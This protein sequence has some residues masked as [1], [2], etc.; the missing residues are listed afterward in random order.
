MGYPEVSLCKLKKLKKYPV[1]SSRNQYCLMV[2]CYFSKWLECFPVPDQ[3]VTTVARKLVYE[4]VARYGAFR[5]LHSDQGTSFGSKVVGEVCQLFGI[6][7]TRTMPYHP[8]S[9]GFIER[10]FR[11]LGRCLKVACRETRREW[12]ELVPLIL[13]SYRAMPQASTGVTPKMMMLGRQMR[14]PL[15]AI[16][17]APLEPDGQEQTISEYVKALQEGLRAPRTGAESWGSEDR[18]GRTNRPSTASDLA[19]GASRGRNGDIG[20]T[21][22]TGC[23]LPAV[24]PGLEP[25]G[26]HD[27]GHPLAPGQTGGDE[28]TVVPEGSGGFSLCP[29]WMRGVAPRCRGVGPPGTAQMLAGS[30]GH[31]NRQGTDGSRHAQCHGGASP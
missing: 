17:G 6:H 13:M 25:R 4:I 30:A 12:D 15:Q 27:G 16:Y 9:N 5:E 14:L 24:D 29:G 28:H 3:K 7:K 10:S 20:P 22:Q 11:T 31:H 2:G 18:Q 19:G 8:R 21:Q 23:G 1:T 26:Q